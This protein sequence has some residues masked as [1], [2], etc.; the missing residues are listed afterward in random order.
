M[1]D[2]LP[3]CDFR[4]RRVALITPAGVQDSLRDSEIL[5]GFPILPWRSSAESA[6]GS[7]FDVAL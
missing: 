5:R 7:V 1:R 4:C 2:S 6:A 3:F